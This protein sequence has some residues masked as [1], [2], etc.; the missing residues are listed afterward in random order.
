MKPL[1]LLLTKCS[2]CNITKIVQ[3]ICTLFIDFES[4]CYH[5]YLITSL[6][7][8]GGTHRGH[9]VCKRSHMVHEILPFYV[10]VHEA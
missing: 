10:S 9:C 5:Y 7:G 3:N 1:L 8:V 6:T 4:P 2:A